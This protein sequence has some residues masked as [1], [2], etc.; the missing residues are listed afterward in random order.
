MGSKKQLV[1]NRNFKQKISRKHLCSFRTFWSSDLQLTVLLD[2]EH[3]IFQSIVFLAQ[4][5]VEVF[6]IKLKSHHDYIL[7]LSYVLYNNCKCVLTVKD[8]SDWQT[9]E[10]VWSCVLEFESYFKF[11]DVT[12]YCNLMGISFLM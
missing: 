8:E 6:L 9:F 3:T 11:R 1:K 12:H 7:V 4:F 10:M 5:V 2:S